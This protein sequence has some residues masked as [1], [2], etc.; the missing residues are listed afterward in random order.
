MPSTIIRYDGSKVVMT[1]VIVGIGIAVGGCILYVLSFIYPYVPDDAAIS[2]GRR[3]ALPTG[4]RLL[5]HPLA[6]PMGALIGGG[7]VLTGAA[8]WVVFKS[9]LVGALELTSTGISTLWRFPASRVAWSEVARVDI[10]DKGLCIVDRAGATRIE[11]PIFLMQQTPSEIAD[12]I[13]RYRAGSSDRAGMRRPRGNG[14]GSRA[15]A[16]GRR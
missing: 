13:Q 16:F 6:A 15:A 5:V 10:H 3:G 8:L 4:L 11:L 2:V 14:E 7:C 9:K 1:F 12:L